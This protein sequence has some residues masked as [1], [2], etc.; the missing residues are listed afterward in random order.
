MPHRSDWIRPVRI[1]LLAVLFVGV[2]TCASV[3]E[4]H[5]TIKADED[6]IRGDADTMEIRIQGEIIS[7]SGVQG[8]KPTISASL[9]SAYSSESIPITLTGNHFELWVPVHRADWYS[10]RIDASSGDRRQRTSTAIGRLALRQKAL[11]GLTLELQRS[12]RTVT[13]DVTHGGSPVADAHV[14]VEMLSGYLLTGNTDADGVLLVDLLPKEKIRAFTV[15]TDDHRFGGFQFGRQPVRDPNADTQT[16]ELADCRDQTIRVVDGN[17]ASLA[18][19][20]MQLQVATPAP[21]VN[22]LGTIDASHMVT[23]GRGEAIFPWFPD[24]KDIRCYVE[25]EGDQWV[26]DGKSSWIDGVF[27]VKVKSKKP[28]HKVVGVLNRPVG[29]KAGFCVSWR[30]FEGEK[31]W[32]SDHLTSVTDREGRFSAE[33]LAGATYAVFVNDEKHVSDMI[34]LIPFPED[35]SEKPIATISIGKSTPVEIRLTAGENNNPIA[36]QMLHVRQTHSYQWIEDGKTKFG[37]SARDKAATTDDDGKAIVH[38]EAGKEIEVS[39][40]NPDWRTSKKIAVVDGQKNLVELHREFDTPRLVLGIV[41]NQ[42]EFPIDFND[43]IVIAGSVDGKTRGIQTLPVRDDGMFSLETMATSV[44]MLAMTKDGKASGVITV[45]N[46]RRLLRMQLQPTKQF[47]G[48]LLDQNKQPIRGRSVVA[49]FRIAHDRED[50]QL[51]AFPL[52]FEAKMV[53]TKTDDQGFYAIDNVPC[54]IKLGVQ[55][56]SSTKQQDH[57]LGSFEI[58]A[59]EQTTIKTSQ[60]PD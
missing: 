53:K 50:N 58:Q 6:W 42:K 24:W 9:R 44:G 29:S 57:W 39:I 27:V 7:S 31:E 55:A 60:V 13:V 33:V 32:T 22:Y 36:N 54:D 35:D 34:D 49:H 46:P 5:V 56:E 11:D 1:C 10:L 16:I 30:S 43:V 40:Y 8:L 51:N 14:K 4:D 23:D 59:G 52:F 38:A 18:G 19:V 12:T 17:G 21:N 37:S 3:S 28:R 2:T 25:L 15:W 48:R 20:K 26:Q 47:R 41:V 45:D